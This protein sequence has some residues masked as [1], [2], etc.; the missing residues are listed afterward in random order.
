[1]PK[2]TLKSR[3]AARQ[4]PKKT[5]RAT[6]DLFEAVEKNIGKLKVVAEAAKREKTAPMKR[7]VGDDGYSAAVGRLSNS[8]AVEI[9]A[10]E[11]ELKGPSPEAWFARLDGE[12]AG[13]EGALAWF[14][15]HDQEQGL[16]LGGTVWPLQLG[17][18]CWSVAGEVVAGP[19]LSVTVTKP[20][21]SIST[22]IQLACPATASSMQLSMTSAKR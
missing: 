14:L 17:Y 10:A 20:P 15:E 1:M 12:E 4:H 6:H 18:C 2:K 8:L 21:G 13:L 19:P 9:V 22:S 16:R 11:G 3:A 7:A 5:G